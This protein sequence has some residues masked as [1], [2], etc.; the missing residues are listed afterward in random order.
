MGAVALVLLLAAF[1][2]VPLDAPLLYRG[3]LLA[4]GLLSAIVIGGCLADGGLARALSWAPLRYIGRVSYGAYLFHWPV[5]L[6]LSPE[7]TGAGDFALFVVREPFVEHL[8]DDVFSCVGNV[9][10]R[11]GEVHLRHAPLTEPRDDVVL[12]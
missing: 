5:F 6:W 8:E 3:G 1:S 2:A 4:V 9:V 12:A 11:D 7:R 10:A